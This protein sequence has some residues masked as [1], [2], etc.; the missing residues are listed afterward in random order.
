MSYKSVWDFGRYPFCGCGT[1]AVEAKL[2]G[3]Q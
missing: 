2:Q 3:I 1:L